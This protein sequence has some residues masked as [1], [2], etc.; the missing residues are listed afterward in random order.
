M[1]NLRERFFEI[2]SELKSQGYTQ[3]KIS[4]EIGVTQG[5]ISSYLR[6]DSQIS[7]PVA[8]LIEAKFGYRKDWLLVGEEPKKIDPEKG[9][10]I[11]DLEFSRKI[12]K[13][14]ELKEI[15]EKILE[16]KKTERDRLFAVIKG[17]LGL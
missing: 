3:T 13:D 5:A 10:I 6:G 4:E 2:Y 12:L 8:I 15:V 11:Q 17:F 9:K 7:I 14:P 16:L 1:S